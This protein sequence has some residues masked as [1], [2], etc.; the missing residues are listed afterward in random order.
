MSNLSPWVRWLCDHSQHSGSG[1]TFQVVVHSSWR[2]PV[3]I[4][5]QWSFHNTKKVSKHRQTQACTCGA[6][7]QSVASVLSPF[8]NDCHGWLECPQLNKNTF[9][10]TWVSK[11]GT[12][13]PSIWQV[14]LMYW[15]PATFSPL[16]KQFSLILLIYCHLFTYFAKQTTLCT[17]L[18]KSSI[19]IFLTATSC[20]KTKKYVT[21]V[22]DPKIDK[23]RTDPA[24]CS[25]IINFKRPAEDKYKF[26]HTFLLKKLPPQL[27][28]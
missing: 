20:N 2:K 14:P 8:Q 25:P 17:F 15:I 22:K 23:D 1:G 4:M 3:W 9:F 6:E 19:K 5:A 18:L 27:W 11:P 16:W 24:V 28:S 7:V 26:L 21:D 12:F 10:L 13:C